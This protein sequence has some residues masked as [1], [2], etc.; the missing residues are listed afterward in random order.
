MLGT[1]WFQTQIFLPG[2]LFLLQRLLVPIQTILSKN[3]P[4]HK[5]YLLPTLGL[6]LSLKL[7]H[8]HIFKILKCLE[9]RDS[10]YGDNILLNLYP[11]ASISAQANLFLEA[12]NQDDSYESL[13]FDLSDSDIFLDSP[14]S[15]EDLASAI[16][17]TSATTLGPD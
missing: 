16:K 13:P 12:F 2:S 17:N 14:F 3:V 4:L 10:S 11:V 8:G 9:N 5:I 15:L 1:T 7:F 6:C